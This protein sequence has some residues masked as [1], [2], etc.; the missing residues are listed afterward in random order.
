MQRVLVRFVT[1][2]P[3]RQEAPAALLVLDLSLGRV[4][5]ALERIRRRYGTSSERV[6]LNDG[7]VLAVELARAL[8]GPPG[9]VSLAA[10]DAPADAALEV[11]TDLASPRLEWE[12]VLDGLPLGVNGRP[13]LELAE[14]AGTSR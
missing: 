12:Y 3:P 6:L 11:R 9:Q 10:P 13:A 8:G 14:R 5:S 4:L 2:L 1:R 7:S